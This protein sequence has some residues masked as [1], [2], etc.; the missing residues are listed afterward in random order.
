MESHR[1]SKRAIRRFRSVTPKKFP[2]DGLRLEFS[3]K[4]MLDNAR[5]SEGTVQQVGSEMFK[6]PSDCSAVSSVARESTD[7]HAIQGSLLRQVFI[8]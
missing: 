4:V 8:H 2:V 1:K 7:S 5:S 6:C 3:M